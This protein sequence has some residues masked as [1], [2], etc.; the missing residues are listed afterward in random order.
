ME[1]MADFEG[2]NR[3]LR[4]MLREAHKEESGSLRLTEQRDVLLRKLSENDD[5]VKVGNV[6]TL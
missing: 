4:R 1:R 5:L 3:T 6:L 2:T